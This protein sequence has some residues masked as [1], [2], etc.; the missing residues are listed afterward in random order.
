MKI[1]QIDVF[2]YNIPLKAPIA[3]S[4]G[5]IENARNLLIRIHADGLTGWGEGSP[6]WMIVGET[7]ETGFAA[8]QDFAKLLIGQNALDLEGNLNRLD[9]YLPNH[10]TI[11]SAFDMALYDLAAQAAGMPLYTFLGGKQRTL[12]TDE[13]IYINTPERMAAEAVR[14]QA[15]GGVAIK[16]KLGTNLRDDI[17]RVE[18]IR[19]AVGDTIPIR[20]DANQ[21]WNYPTAVNVLQT[22]QGWNIEYCEQPVKQGAIA[23]LK[24]LRE[25]T[26]VPIMA[27]ESLFSHRDALR[28]AQEQAVDYFNIKLSK[29][30][31]IFNALKINA[32]A[33]AAGIPCMIG[34]MS[35]SRLAITAKAHFASARQNVTFFDLDAPFE[36]ATD[37]V[38]GGAVYTGY[39]IGLSDQPGLGAA[40]DSHYLKSLEN[41]T[42]T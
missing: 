32:I 20:T 30:G 14:I 38:I 33:E 31:G 12:I 2:K 15:Q 8:A 35:E 1:N 36:H 26:T 17:R 28:L 22:I 39:H 7:Q 3:I 21:G 5:T 25:K 23:D 34:C 13:T 24:R 16:V 41:W 11:K 10:P 4:L 9:A 6:F 18:A 29:S 27:D 42:I 37:P 19:E 40:V